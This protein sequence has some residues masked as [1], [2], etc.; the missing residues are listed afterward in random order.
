MLEALQAGCQ[1]GLFMFDVARE[2]YRYRPLLGEALEPE[3]FAFRN[4][5]ER[6]AHDLAAE[7]GAVKIVTENHAST[8]EGAWRS[9]PARWPSPP[10]SASTGPRSWSTTTGG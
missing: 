5:R 3:R 1:R 9:S 7:K 8:A 6:R 10:R 4:V 2:V